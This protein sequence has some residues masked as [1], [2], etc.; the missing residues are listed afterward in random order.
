[1]TLS[2]EEIY[3]SFL[4]YITDYNIVSMDE[5][6]AYDVM[7]EWLK[8]AYSKPYVRRL[9]S[10]AL[11]DNEIQMLTY[12][13]D[14]PVEENADNDFVIDVLAKGM[15]IEW[16]QPQVKSKALTAQVFSNKES[17]FFSQSAHLSE[18]QDLLDDTRLE[19]RKIIR[20]RGYINNAYLEGSS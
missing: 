15:V 7:S 5:Q 14:Y 8:K 13:M 18:L 10:T 17:K 3:S 12:E 6:D 4:G 16:V 20:D 2:Y 9:F 19:Q 1:M 11:F